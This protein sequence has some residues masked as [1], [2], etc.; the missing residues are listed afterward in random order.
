M[1]HPL[2]RRARQ[3]A[4]LPPSQYSLTLALPIGRVK[5]GSSTSCDTG[6]DSP[7]LLSPTND[8]SIEVTVTNVILTYIR[9]TVTGLRN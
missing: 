9:Y 5:L 4:A 2:C 3:Q 8:N 1:R 6:N 7:Y